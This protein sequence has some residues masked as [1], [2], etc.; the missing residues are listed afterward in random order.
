MPHRVDIGDGQTI[1]QEGVFGP[2]LIGSATLK[3]DVS[4]ATEAL[5]ASNKQP[6][7]EAKPSQKEIDAEFY[8]AR[9]NVLQPVAAEF[10]YIAFDV[11]GHPNS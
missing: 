10:R 6:Y 4:H 1:Q 8:I 7:F 9:N 11:F 3:P 5:L 2:H